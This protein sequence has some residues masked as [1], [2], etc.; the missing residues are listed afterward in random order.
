MIG[1]KPDNVNAAIDALKARLSHRSPNVKQKGLRLIKHCCQKGSPEFK[2]AMSRHS[3]VL[4][5]LTSYKCAP[6]P[7]KGDIP[8]KRVQEAAKECLEAL[9]AA[10]DNIIMNNNAHQSYLPMSGYANNGGGRRMD[11]FG[12]GTGGSGPSSSLGEM[13]AFGNTPL[14][15]SSKSIQRVSLLETFSTGVNSLGNSMHRPHHHR[16]P[17]TE[18]QWVNDQQSYGQHPA[19]LS[20]PI[21][22]LDNSST[23]DSSNN[24]IQQHSATPEGALVNKI[25]TPSGLRAVPETVD[26]K[27]FVAAAATINVTEVSQIL[28]EKC[29]KGPWQA[30]LRALCA[31]A[32]LIEDGAA[33]GVGGEAAVYFQAHPGTVRKMAG[34]PQA[35]VRQRADRVLK[36]IGAD[37]LPSSDDGKNNNNNNNNDGTAVDLSDL[38]FGDDGGGTAAVEVVVPPTTTAGVDDL[39]SGLDISLSTAAA[40]AAPLPDALFQDPF[41]QAP[42]APSSS[43]PSIAELFFVEQPGID[44][45]NISPQKPS[46]PTTMMM[47]SNGDGMRSM[48][49][50]KG[51]SGSKDGAFNF[52]E[53]QLNEMKVTKKK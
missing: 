28:E 11:G 40:G 20:Q 41:Q 43:S 53:S 34:H 6:D 47:G 33:V 21:A 22:A 37:T 8:W 49:T 17:S 30:S 51:G 46:P 29:E 16:L 9:H 2:R 4:K 44:L 15:A 23:T 7:F 10:P 50:G 3:Y 42:A 26:L 32:A 12:S 38:L 27:A 45:P 18:H 13:M 39:F 36:L 19:V 52:I 35:T 1:N 24:N 31:I 25:C 48:M 14:E 5:D